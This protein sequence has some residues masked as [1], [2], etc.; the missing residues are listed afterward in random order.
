M[1][2][3]RQLYILHGSTNLEDRERISII[4]WILQAISSWSR[5]MSICLGQSLDN[6]VTKSALFLSGGARAVKCIMSCLR[7]KMIAVLSNE[8]FEQMVMRNELDYQ[9]NVLAFNLQHSDMM[10][11]FPCTAPLCS[12]VP[13]CFRI[14]IL[15]IKDSV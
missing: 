1:G 10:P 8:I 4:I 2:F 5:I 7:Q 15:L 11:D 13:D 9:T 3:R 14:V 12:M 6:I